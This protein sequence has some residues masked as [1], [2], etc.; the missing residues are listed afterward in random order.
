LHVK[1]E[2]NIVDRFWLLTSTTYGNWLPGDERGFV[3]PNRTPLGVQTIHNRPGTE[4]DR[5]VSWLR[6]HA[7]S[8][9]KGPPIVFTLGHAEVLLRQL[10]ET[11]THRRWKLS[12]VGIMATHAHRRRRPRRSEPGG[13]PWQLQELWESRAQP[14]MGAAEV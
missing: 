9:L 6:E 4:Y 11:A 13:R 1:K 14:E 3:G 5:D 2:E 7:Q 8:Q 10:Y 12:A